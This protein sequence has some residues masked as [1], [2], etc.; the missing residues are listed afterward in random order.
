[1]TLL[2]KSNGQKISNNSCINFEDDEFEEQIS[3]HE[4][5]E[6]SH[7]LATTANV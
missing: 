4:F 2:F 3:A 7:E 6:R 5:E 1:M